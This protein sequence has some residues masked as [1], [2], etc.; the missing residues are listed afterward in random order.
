MLS[1]AKA[2]AKAAR[3]GYRRPVLRPGEIFNPATGEIF[4]GCVTIGGLAASLGVTTDCLTDEMERLGMVNR[5][6]DYREVPMVCEPAFRKP[7]YFHTPAPTKNATEQG[8][9]LSIKAKRDYRTYRILLI[10]PQGQD[11]I[12][13]A[14]RKPVKPPKRTDRNKE[15]IARLH[16]AGRSPAEIVSLAAIPKRTVFRYLK[17]IRQAA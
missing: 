5:V 4:T 1:A 17:A 14:F 15:V 9:A 7:R 6:L 16:N 8:L 10:A 3:E 2:E 12:R 13:A 11:A